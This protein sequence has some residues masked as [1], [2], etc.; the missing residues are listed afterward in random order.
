MNVYEKMLQACMKNGQI[1]LAIET[2]ERSR[3]RHL[4]DLMASNNI[5]PDAQISEAALAH[6]ERYEHLQAR[7][8]Q[9]QFSATSNESRTLETAGTRWQ[10]AE[11]ISADI[12]EINRLEAEKQQV[13]QQLR[14][15]DPIL[16]GQKQVDPIKFDQIQQLIDDNFTAILC[17]YSTWEDTYIFIV[18]KDRPPQVHR[19]GGQNIATLFNEFLSNNWLTPYMEDFSRW[20][21]N[22]PAVLQ[23]LAQRLKL[24]ELIDKY[25]QGIE[26]LIII[27]HIWLHQIPFAALPVGWVGNS[28]NTAFVPNPSRPHPQPL[29]CEERGDK[30][31]G[32]TSGSSM[33]RGMVGTRSQPDAIIPENR[34]YLGDLF[35]LRILPSCQILNYCYQRPTLQETTAMGIVENASEDLPYTPYECETIATKHQID[36]SKRLQG[37]Q[38]TVEAYRQ[39]AQQVPKLHS[40]HHA[41]ANP[42]NP[43][44]SVLVLSDRTLPLGEL[45]TWRIP[46]LRDVFLNNCET[47]F[48]VNEITDD[49]LTIATGFLCV[50]ARNVVSTIWEVDDC[51]SA[52]LAIF[53][54]DFRHAGSSR[55]QAL[56][57]AQQKLRTMTGKQLQDEYYDRLDLHLRQLYQQTL[58]SAQA[59]KARGEEDDRKYQEIADKIDRQIKETLPHHCQQKYPF[60]SPFYWAGFISQGLA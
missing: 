33:T 19:C 52:L 1:D 21:G 54:Y 34:R 57:Q 3:G 31:G 35:R 49:L 46:N 36:S 29:S 55:S 32:S 24:S 5:D 12:A 42:I 20:L 17:F 13:W 14:R 39:L 11:V 60:A 37:R 30:R 23:E 47:N 26:E 53:Y 15:L 50:G 56:Q 41:S 6:A 45:L 16:A 51:A 22:M 27:P 58:A 28:T 44:E 8:Y 43:L 9:L 40:S 25:L 18:Y 7:I 38:A 59:A 2:T 4:V 10:S 48:S